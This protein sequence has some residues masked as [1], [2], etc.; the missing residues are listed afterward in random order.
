MMGPPS[1]R[2]EAAW[3]LAPDKMASAAHG[4]R[5]S[6]G[7]KACRTPRRTPSRQVQVEIPGDQVVDEL[8][9][10]G[11]DL[12]VIADGIRDSPGPRV[13]QTACR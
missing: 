11:V 8:Y 6:C 1:F 4:S 10:S 9:A 5:S 13:T 7:M 3:A 12:D 2:A